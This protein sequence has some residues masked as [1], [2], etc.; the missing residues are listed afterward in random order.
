MP[1]DEDLAGPHLL[2]IGY[3]K[4]ASTFLQKRLFP[5]I[6]SRWFDRPMTTL[7]CR[8][9][10]GED[11]YLER[12]FASYL[13]EQSDHHGKPGI[14]SF[15]SLAGHIWEGSATTL[16][17]AKRLAR[18]APGA[19]VL[20]IVRSQPAMLVA[21]YG[22]YVNEG[23]PGSFT[24]FLSGD[25]PGVELDP[26]YLDFQFLVELYRDLFPDVV[27]V[28]YERFRDDPKMFIAGICDLLGSPF[29]DTPTFLD[30]PTT[31][32]VGS[33][34]LRLSN[35]GFRRSSF[36]PDPPLAMPGS[37]VVRAPLQRLQIGRSLWEQYRREAEVFCGRFAQSNARLQQ[38][39]NWDLSEY[40]YPLP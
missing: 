29:V 40:G 32:T 5:K 27:I 14:V 21:L 15:E 38:T 22:Q 34:L 26:S 39:C 10:I 9:L 2:H 8:N 20:V 24:R 25:L 6:E 17:T 30:N 16:R 36:N 37:R 35:K 33:A 18:A 23:G 12:T 7:L 31:S 3:Q 19:T 1:H 13:A 4:T 11:V 28:P